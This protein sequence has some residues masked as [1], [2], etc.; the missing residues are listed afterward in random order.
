MERFCS[1]PDREMNGNEQDTEASENSF[2]NLNK[3]EFEIHLSTRPLRQKLGSGAVSG[4]FEPNF[5]RIKNP[6]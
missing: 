6:Y 4:G 3:A 5:K 1:S 2:V